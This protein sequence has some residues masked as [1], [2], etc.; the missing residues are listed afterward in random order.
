[1]H[2]HHRLNQDRRGGR[3][4]GDSLPGHQ[5]WTDDPELPQPTLKFDQFGFHANVQVKT[6]Q[7]LYYAPGRSRLLAIVLVRDIPGQRP[8]ELVWDHVA[9]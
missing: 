1:M 9:A 4:N 3:V 8:A 7:A 2:R 5:A 6:R